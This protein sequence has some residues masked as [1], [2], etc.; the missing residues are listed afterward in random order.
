MGKQEAVGDGEATKI[1]T[2]NHGN[3]YV[4]GDFSSVEVETLLSLKLIKYNA[5]G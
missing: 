2:D 4:L 3:I 5:T 1:V